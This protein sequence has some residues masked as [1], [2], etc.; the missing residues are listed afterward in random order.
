M[1]SKAKSLTFHFVWLLA[2]LWKKA[3]VFFR[4]PGSKC[5]EPLILRAPVLVLRC[6]PAIWP[7]PPAEWGRFK[8][9]PTE[10]QLPKSAG[11]YQYVNTVK[12]TDINKLLI[13]QVQKT[14]EDDHYRRHLY[15]AVSC[16]SSADHF[17][18]R[19]IFSQ[20]FMAGDDNA[21]LSRQ[22]KISS[23]TGRVNLTQLSH[24]TTGRRLEFTF[25]PG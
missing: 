11:Q 1:T 23:G 25:G 19:M 18:R 24:K 7:G 4:A 15:K 3:V 21:L 13:L 20:V 10:A 12:T 9:R 16:V 5:R 2:T 8:L 6:H 22:G 14:P 17:F